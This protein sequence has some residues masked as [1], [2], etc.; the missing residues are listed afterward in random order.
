MNTSN[1]AD[2]NGLHLYYEVHGEGFP[3]IL[4]HGGY[5]TTDMFGPVRQALAQGRQ[6]IAAELQGHGRTGDIRRPLRFETL[7]DDMAALIDCLGVEQVD[8]MGYS[9]GGGAA[10]RTAIQYPL[11]I[12]KLI[13]VSTP[14]KQSG[15]YPEVLAGM[16]S[17][18]EPG[19]AEQMKRTPLYE[20]YRPIA[21]RPEDFSVLVGKMGRLL[22]RRYNWGDE[23][24]NIKAQ[25][26]LVFG[27]HDSIHPEHMI[28]FFKRL[29]GGQR[30]AGWDGSGVSNARLA[31]LPGTTHYNIVTSPRLAAA[32]IPF[33]EGKL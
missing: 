15:W 23:L 22:S 25:A 30:D 10:L 33:L 21:P 19:A 13:L 17:Q 31:I 4:L 12:R 18:R 14:F 24:G 32:A 3:L 5:G 2:V 8:L 28:D 26:L 20:I 1:Y 11:K 9:L 29:G 7:A 6:V 16:R 27:D